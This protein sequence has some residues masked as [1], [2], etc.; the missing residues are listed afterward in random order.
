MLALDF[1][2]VIS[3]SFM[4][5]CCSVVLFFYCV[6]IVILSS[7]HIPYMIYTYKYALQILKNRNLKECKHLVA[8]RP[9][10]EK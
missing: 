10:I 7:T 5:F 8:Y 9:R 3:F 4:K 1:L 6:H 2:L